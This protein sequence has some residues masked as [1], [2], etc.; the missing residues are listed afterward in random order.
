MLNS[1]TIN[2]TDRTIQI[3]MRDL[4]KDEK[5][6]VYEVIWIKQSMFDADNE[7][8]LLEKETGLELSI[9]WREFINKFSL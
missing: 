8:V 4:H 6:I 5:W 7:I 2:L 9:S 3:N 1:Y